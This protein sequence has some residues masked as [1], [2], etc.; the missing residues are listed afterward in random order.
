MEASI[1][2][3]G[4]GTLDLLGNTPFAGDP[5]AAGNVLANDFDPDS[6]VLTVSGVA[7]GTSAGPVS[8]NVGIPVTGTYGTLEITSVDFG[9]AK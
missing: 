7:A 2:S 8:G 5:S 9:A 3:H 6:Y 1:F 4:D